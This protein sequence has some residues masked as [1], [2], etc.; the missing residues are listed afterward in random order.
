MSDRRNPTLRLPKEPGSL[1][2]V[3]PNERI[4]LDAEYGGY[5]AAVSGRVVDDDGTPVDNVWVSAI[6]QGDAPL[7]PAPYVRS[8]NGETR[9]LTSYEGGFELRGLAPNSRYTVLVEQPIGGA[10]TVQRG[11]SSGNKDRVWP[12]LPP[13]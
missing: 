5:D 1:V 3:R 11:V 2:E 12:R 9:T 13:S 10:A 8:I 7:P 6:P 4:V